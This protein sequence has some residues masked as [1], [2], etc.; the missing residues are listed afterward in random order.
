MESRYSV[1]L[2]KLFLER[3]LRAGLDKSIKIEKGLDIPIG[4]GRDE[5]YRFEAITLEIEES[6]RV[7]SHNVIV[8]GINYCVYY[9]ESFSL[10]VDK[11]KRLKVGDLRFESEQEPARR[12]NAKLH[13]AYIGFRR[14]LEEASLDVL[15]ELGASLASSPEA[16]SNYTFDAMSEFDEAIEKLRY[17]FY[18]RKVTPLERPVIDEEEAKSFYKFLMNFLNKIRDKAEDMIL[19]EFIRYISQRTIGLIELLIL[20]LIWLSIMQ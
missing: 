14:Y 17:I 16:I 19:E 4:E 11:K 3:G 7:I 9:P 13:A 18:Q 6:E 1:V 20:Y 10:F 5:G 2:A 8:G 12:M 15:D